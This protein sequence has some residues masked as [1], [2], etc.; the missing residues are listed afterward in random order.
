MRIAVLIAALALTLTPAVAQAKVKSAPVP[1]APTLETEAPPIETQPPATENAVSA[2]EPDMASGEP[3]SVQVFK[4]CLNYAKGD[5]QAVEAAKA[6]GWDAFEDQGESPFVKSYSGNKSFAGVGD[7]ALF[8]L[9]ESYPNATF[10]YCR[11]DMQPS[12]SEDGN[13]S[14]LGEANVNAL[15]DLPELAGGQVI[16]NGD[17][18]FGSWKGAEAEP[19]M[20][21]LSHQTADAYVLQMT[22]ITHRDGP[23]EPK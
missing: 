20:L 12:V 2:G 19:Q 6:L 8:S 13:Q 15:R 23:A 3:V 11:V 21:L 18:T 10:G 9:V 17:G 7:A 16:T 14:P 5:A 22:I 1:E 4:A